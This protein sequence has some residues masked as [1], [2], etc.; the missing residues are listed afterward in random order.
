MEAV[1]V[2]D[3]VGGDPACL[4]V[5]LIILKD[6]CWRL[7][8]QGKDHLDPWAPGAC[9]EA[10]H[11]TTPPPRGGG[12]PPGAG[13]GGGGGGGVRGGAGGGEGSWHFPQLLLND[14]KTKMSPHKHFQAL[15]LP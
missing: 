15:L 8:G 13:G 5:L 4:V 14:C 6:S 7:K 2:E 12:G 1:E 9:W 11:V 10:S 3:A